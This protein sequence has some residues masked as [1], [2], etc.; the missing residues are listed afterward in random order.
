[1]VDEKGTDSGNSDEPI[2]HN[3]LNLSGKTLRHAECDFSGHVFKGKANF[4]STTFDGKAN[5]EGATFK[6][7]ANFSRARFLAGASFEEAKFINE[8]DVSFDSAMFQNK[9]KVS[10]YSA[11]FENEGNIDFHS[12]RF[13]NEGEVSFKSTRFV[14][15]GSV[16]F[17]S[18]RFKNNGDVSFARAKCENKGIVS[19]NSARFENKDNVWFIITKFANEG[20]VLFGSARFENDGSVLFIGTKFENKGNVSFNSAKFK[21]KGDISFMQVPW[22]NDGQLNFVNAGFGDEINVRFLECFFLCK[23]YISFE[24][25]RFPEKGSLVFQRCYFELTGNVIFTGAFFRHTMFEGG[26]VEWISFLLESTNSERWAKEQEEEISNMPDAV[27]ELIKNKK[28]SF[29]TNVFHGG[30]T[31]L[32]KDLT[33]E[34]AKHLTFRL[35]D[36]SSAKFDGMTLTHIQLN[37]PTWWKENG[38]SMLYEEHEFREAQKKK[39]MWERFK[40]YFSEHTHEKKMQLQ[41]LENQYTQLKTN[42]E[43]QGDYFQAGQFHYGEQELRRLR[44]SW[45]GR[46]LSL[47]SLYRACSGYGEEASRSFI[48]VLIVIILFSGMLLLIDF[49]DVLHNW[50]PSEILTTCRKIVVE[51]ITPFS[52]KGQPKPW[53]FK[54]GNLYYLLL[55]GGQ[56]LLYIQISLFVLAV[57]RRFKR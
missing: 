16:L 29:H 10:F 8:G 45:W 28:E 49:K 53:A 17:D 31:V 2:T 15:K 24:L 22:V 51:L 11:S 42:L 57:R 55:I 39:P 9:G 14:N 38:R 36:L 50:N 5:F 40:E 41:N 35:T 18:A 46:N 56:I 13:E 23:D 48:Y 19:F 44:T 34:S 47:L 12:A 30:A 54:K 33:P 26:E 21:N 7:G 4:F 43:R 37:A 6:N 27:K 52:W 20:N 1:M 25:A 3:N 32:F